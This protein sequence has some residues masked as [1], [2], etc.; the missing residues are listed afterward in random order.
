MTGDSMEVYLELGS[1]G[2][3][4]QQVRNMMS[5]GLRLAGEQHCM[6]AEG[7]VP[8]PGTNRVLVYN[9]GIDGWDCRVY[10]EDAQ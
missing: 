10:I 2:L 8:I 7:R 3:S 9:T 4:A 6:G 1:Y 5:E